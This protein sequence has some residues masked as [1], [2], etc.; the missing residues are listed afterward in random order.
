MRRPRGCSTTP[1]AGTE[2]SAPPY[3]AGA[4]VAAAIE[5]TCRPDHGTSRVHS[6]RNLAKPSSSPGS[7]TARMSDSRPTRS[8]RLIVIGALGLSSW[9]SLCPDGDDHVE[10]VGVGHRLASGYDEV[11]GVEPVTASV[12][13]SELW[14]T[15]SPTLHARRIARA[16]IAGQRAVVRPSQVLPIDAEA[17]EVAVAGGATALTK[18]VSNLL[19]P[20]LP[21]GAAATQPSLRMEVGRARCP[22]CAS[23]AS[24]W[25]TVGA[26]SVEHVCRPRGPHASG[27]QRPEPADSG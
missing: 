24:E 19:W 13:A 2:V 11:G 3:C 1:A 18:A 22:E 15:P 16:V 12:G 10:D 7:R 9:V 21:G 5:G 4:V 26:V 8:E 23:D 27:A 17:E 6:P 14:S 20:G 25:L